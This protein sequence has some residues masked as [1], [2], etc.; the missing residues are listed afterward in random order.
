MT[1][2][3]GSTTLHVLKTAYTLCSMCAIELMRYLLGDCKTIQHN[4]LIKWQYIEEEGLVLG[5]K[6]SKAHTDYTKHK[7]NV[8]VAAQTISSAVAEAVD[9]LRENLSKKEF[10]GCEETIYTFLRKVTKLFDILN[11]KNIHGRGSKAALSANNMNEWRQYLDQMYDYL[12]TLKDEKGRLL[13]SGRRKTAII[14]FAVA[15]K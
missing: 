12:M 13:R 9:F 1:R 2:G 8:R 4:K 15:T 6:L 10:D 7:M 14:G 11:S 5:N 3:H